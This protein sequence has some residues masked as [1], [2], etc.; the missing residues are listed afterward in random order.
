M[1]A[2]AENAG[3]MVNIYDANGKVRSTL[4]A[5]FMNMLNVFEKVVASVQAGRTN[6]GIVT[7]HDANGEIRDGLHAQTR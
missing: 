7:V 6:E 2:N 5:G 4:Q 1:S 3:G